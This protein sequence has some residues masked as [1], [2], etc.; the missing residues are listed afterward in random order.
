MFYENNCFYQ[1][2]RTKKKRKKTKFWTMIFLPTNTDFNKQFVNWKNK[3]PDEI[4][5]IEINKKSLN[6][7]KNNELYEQK[8][9]FK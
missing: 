8:I 4:I 6:S 3:Y 5:E 2:T 7:L 9:K 1:K